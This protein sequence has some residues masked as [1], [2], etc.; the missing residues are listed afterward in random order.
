M[1]E[2]N[3]RDYAAE[4]RASLEN[5]AQR[6]GQLKDDLLTGKLAEESV[7]MAKVMLLCT[8][9]YSRPKVRQL[10][11]TARLGDGSTLQVTF[12]A[13]IEGVELPF[14]SDARLL[15]WLLH[16]SFEIDSPLIPWDSVYEYL[17]QIGRKTRGGHAYQQVRDS[18]MRICGL[19]VSLRSKT[20]TQTKGKNFFIIHA[21]NLPN[22]MPSDENSSNAKIVPAQYDPSISKGVLIDPS[23]QGEYMRDGS[24]VAIPFELWMM[25]KGNRQLQDMVLFFYW[26][27]YSAASESVIPWEA[28]ADQFGSFSNPWRQRD[29]AREAVTFLRGFWPG[30]K[31]EAIDTGILVDRS[32]PLLPN[33]P[34]RKRIRLLGR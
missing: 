26:R 28:L 23:F 34:A 7:H 32:Q 2:I 24:H 20:F 16:R 12:T 14:G 17:D 13:G 27:C 19:G 11:R 1:S 30:C 22:F 33:D 21:Y 8:L 9:P 31:I 6:L 4:R 15:A 18:F 3:P 10:G 29:Y 5:R 25:L